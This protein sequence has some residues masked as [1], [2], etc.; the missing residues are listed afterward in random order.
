M[1]DTSGGSAH[2]TWLLRALRRAGLGAAPPSSDEVS[3]SDGSGSTSA[4]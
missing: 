2:D 1:R 4:L 3:S